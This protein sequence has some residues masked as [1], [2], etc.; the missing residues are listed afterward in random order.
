MHGQR[1]I[2]HAIKFLSVY[3]FR[4]FLY[5]VLSS[6]HRFQLDKHVIKSEG[7]GEGRLNNALIF[8][9]LSSM[10]IHVLW[11]FYVITIQKIRKHISFV[12]DPI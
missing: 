10:G 2:V 5:F 11:V 7:D 3:I 6:S 4:P 9:I 8:Q 1:E 12:V